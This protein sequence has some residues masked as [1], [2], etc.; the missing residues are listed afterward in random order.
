MSYYIRATGPGTDLE[1]GYL[2]HPMKSLPDPP[3][4]PFDRQGQPI[5]FDQPHV[6]TEQVVQMTQYTDTNPLPF[7]H[8]VGVGLTGDPAPRQINQ[9]QFLSVNED[10]YIQAGP[11]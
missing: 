4:F 1:V 2:Q 9:P 7:Q 10:I 3:G 11:A 8:F 5:P 6:S